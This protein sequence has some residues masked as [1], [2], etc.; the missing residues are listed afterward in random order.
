MAENGNFFKQFSG[1]V[2][3]TGKKYKVK[4]QMSNAENGTKTFHV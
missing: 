2:S 4:R 3:I 1:L